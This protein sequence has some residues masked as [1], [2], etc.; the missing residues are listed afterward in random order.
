MLGD[1][2]YF[3]ENVHGEKRMRKFLA[4]LLCL[5]LVFSVCA[6]GSGNN[7]N[8]NADNEKLA[9]SDIPDTCDSPD[10]TYDIA[11]VTTNGQL[12]DA[13]FNQAAWEGCKAYGYENDITYKY[14]NPVGGFEAGDEEITAAM[15]EACENGAKVV[16]APGYGHEN[17]LRT[18]A[19]EYPDI[20]FI[21]IDG[22]DLDISNVES[23]QY[24]EEQ[25][26]YFAG[27][28]VVSEGYENL[29]FVGGGSGN[30]P[31]CN[32]FGYGFAQGA[33]DAA[34]ELGK[35]INMRYS[36]ENGADFSPSPEL[37]AMLKGWYENGTEAIFVCGGTMFDSCVAAAEATGGKVIGVDVD[38]SAFSKTVITSALKDIRGSVEKTIEKYYTEGIYG[39]PLKMGVKDEAVGI[40]KDTWSFKNWTIEEY[41]NLYQ[42]T[43]LG[44]MIIDDTDAP[45][46]SIMGLENTNF[47]K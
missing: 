12:K 27:Y 11:L 9:Y 44:D 1:D 16:V 22:N 4:T 34:A 8:T 29:G 37:E 15:R 2:S 14:Y 20:Q 19:P 21:F 23:V 24:H 40:P 5:L 35:T 39:G 26:G 36:W 13:S 10:G 25:A 47:I 33:D 43:T 28:A 31:A 7:E 32:R 41:E 3:I 42:K 17:T 45:D 38:Q 18:V 30:N 46:P 6:C